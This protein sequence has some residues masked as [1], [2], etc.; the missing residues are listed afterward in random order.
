MPVALEKYMPFGIKVGKML[1]VHVEALI[2]FARLGT[3][4]YECPCTKVHEAEPVL[5]SYPSPVGTA[6]STP[7]V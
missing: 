1:Y 4:R 3:S 2:E 6:S 5:P 7:I